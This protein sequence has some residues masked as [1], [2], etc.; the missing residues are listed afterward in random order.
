MKLV[1]FGATGPTGLAL[2]QQALHAGHEVTAL[3]RN[4][5]RMTIAHPKLRIVQGDVL[6]PP[7]VEQVVIGAEAVLSCL[8]VKPFAGKQVQSRAGRHIV[9]AMQK[10]G[11]RRFIM[12]S[13]YGVAESRS[14]ASPALRAMISV[15]LSWTYNDKEVEEAE[16]KASGLDWTIIRPT[17]LRNGPRTGKY[18][19]GDDLCLGLG[20]WINRA[21]VADFMLKQLTSTE[22]VRRT[23]AITN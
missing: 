2:T 18:R 4:P 5:A 12:E 3:A 1:I 22:W 21:D 15:F 19:V 10:H 13:A 6:D 11:V 9:S 17:A 20:T 14:L 23:P 7:A 8:G 16:I